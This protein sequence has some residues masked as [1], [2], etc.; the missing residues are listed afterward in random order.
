MNMSIRVLAGLLVI[1]VVLHPKAIDVQAVRFATPN[2]R[3]IMVAHVKAVLIWV[4]T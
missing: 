1:S 2:H 4:G 3:F